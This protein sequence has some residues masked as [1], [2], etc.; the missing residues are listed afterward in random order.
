MHMNATVQRV[1]RDPVT[2]AYSL[3]GVGPR[4][5][6][7]DDANRVL[8]RRSSEGIFYVFFPGISDS[9]HNGGRMVAAVSLAGAA[10]RTIGYFNV[11]D[12]AQ[13]D[14]VEVD[15]TQLNGTL[16]DNGF[17]IQLFGFRRI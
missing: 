14:I 7:A 4:F 1:G 17:S 9:P 11:E 6:C 13:D 2:E 3:R 10:S 12:G 16:Q 15:I 5:N 8:I